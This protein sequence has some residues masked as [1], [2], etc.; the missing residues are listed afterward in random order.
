MKMNKV[1]L[2]IAAALVAV[3]PFIT[4]QASACAWS[5]GETP[6]PEALKE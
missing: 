5:A 3:A 2:A 6:I 4:I 1:L